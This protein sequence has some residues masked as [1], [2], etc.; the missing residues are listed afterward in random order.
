M[1]NLENLENLE[2]S[3]TSKININIIECASSP[4][5]FIKWI[6]TDKRY[7]ISTSFKYLNTR[8]GL[9][10]NI[11]RDMS[12]INPENSIKY[13]LSLLNNQERIELDNGINYCNYIDEK[14]KTEIFYVEREWLNDTNSTVVFFSLNYWSLA[15][16]LEH[17]LSTEV[18]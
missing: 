10:I 12:K 9:H 8:Y 16:Y 15:D 17:K 13:L 7:R 14:N 4:Y 2:G 6:R 18:E 1:E 11:I 3:I 5:F